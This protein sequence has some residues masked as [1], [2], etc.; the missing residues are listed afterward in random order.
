MGVADFIQN[1]FSIF[2]NIVNLLS[3]K[4]LGILAIGKV[5]SYSKYKILTRGKIKCLEFAAEDSKSI[6][7]RKITFRRL[8]I[9]FTCTHTSTMLMLT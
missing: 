6:V 4:L 2:L 5:V 9:K 7:T 1:N 8:K 3:F